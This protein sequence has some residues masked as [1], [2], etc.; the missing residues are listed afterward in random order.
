VADFRRESGIAFNSILK[1]LS[2]F[3]ER[4]RDEVKVCVDAFWES[5]VEAAASNRA[6]SG[7]D[8]EQRS[9]DASA[10]PITDEC[11]SDSRKG[12]GDQK[13]PRQTVERSLEIVER[14]T[15]VI[16]GIKIWDWY[17]NDE[18]G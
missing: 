6:G 9:E 16:A 11:T 5:S 2:H 18:L 12:G 15:L 3:I 1:R 7:A 13:C 4:L 10:R 14:D 8:I 17:A